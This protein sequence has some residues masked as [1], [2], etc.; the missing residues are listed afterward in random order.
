MS[1][2]EVALQIALQEFFISAK[3]QKRQTNN[4]PEK[5]MIIEIIAFI[6]ALMFKAVC[7]K[8]LWVTMDA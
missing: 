8:P 7:E 1:M 4:I 5:V 2:N 3:N 6:V